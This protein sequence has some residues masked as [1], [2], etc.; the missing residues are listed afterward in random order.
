MDET[1]GLVYTAEIISVT[2]ADT[3]VLEFN[4]TEQRSCRIF[5]IDAP[6]TVYASTVWSS[7]Y[8]QLPATL[9]TQKW[10]TE[11]VARFE[12]LLISNT[13]AGTPVGLDVTVI[14]RDVDVYDRLVVSIQNN[15]DKDVAAEMVLTGH[16]IVWDQYADDIPALFAIYKDNENTAQDQDLVMWS[17]DP[18]YAPWDYRDDVD[19]AARALLYIVVEETQPPEGYTAA[20]LDDDIILT[21]SREIESSYI[22]SDY[23]RLW[24]TNSSLTEFYEQLSCSISKDDMRVILNPEANLSADQYY[25]VIAIGGT[26]GITATDGYKLEENYILSFKTTDTIRPVTD[27]ESQ[28]THVDLWVDG[29]STDDDASGPRD[30]FSTSGADTHIVLLGSIPDNHSVGVADIDK[31]IFLYD[32]TIANVVPRE[33]LYG[34]WSDLPVDS[35]PLGAREIYIS[36]ADTEE[37]RLTFHT[38]DITFTDSL[39]KE[40]VFHL[41]KGAVKGENKE[42]YDPDDH[43]V[44]FMGKL[45]PLYSTPDQIQLRLSGY[46]SSRETGILD[47][48]LYKIIHE[49]SVWTDAKLGAPTTTQEL[50]E[51]NRLI[52]CLVLYDLIA[53]GAMLE[54]GIKSRSLLMTQV[55]YYGPEWRSVLQEL[56]DCIRTGLSTYSGEVATIAHGIKSGKHINRQGKWYNVYR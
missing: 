1:P 6:E 2:D 44:R 52:N 56:D 36:R 43:Y 32:D 18:V 33:A 40:Y 9:Q 7:V 34:R 31:L 13:G 25:M 50:I 16:A 37:N 42:G 10:G 8:A 54:G 46:F 48:D 14:I 23:F 49:K 17:D 15:E 28:I 19:D 22:S 35:D 47:Y 45:T 38:E 11:A 26:A 30:Y 27:V 3:L 29:D 5:G 21:F 51:R 53:H 24:R 4:G 55:E 39:N 12:E 41:A 20:Y